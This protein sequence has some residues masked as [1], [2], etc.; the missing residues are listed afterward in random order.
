[1]IAI[2]TQ[3][4]TEIDWITLSFCQ[5]ALHS[6]QELPIL[7]VSFLVLYQDNHTVDLAT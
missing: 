3:S 2:P 4:L 5:K 6:K 1:M 7:G